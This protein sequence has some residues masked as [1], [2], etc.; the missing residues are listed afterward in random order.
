MHTLLILLS[1]SLASGVC[2]L[3]IAFLRTERSSAARRAVQLVGLFVPV[4]ILGLLGVVMAHFLVKTCF[5]GA[6]PPD[7]AL[8]RVLS[9]VGA[10]GILAALA[11]NTVRALLLPVHMRR[12]TWQA[13]VWLQ[14]RVATLAAQAG[15]RGRP[16]VRV[17]LD[18]RPWALV[19]GL[20]RPCVVISSGLASLLDREELDAVLW[21]ELAHISRR[22]LLYTA[23]AGVLSDLTWFL[24]MTRYLYGLLVAEQ[25]L[26]CDD[27]VR[28]ESHRLALASALTRVRHAQVKPAPSPQGALSFFAAPRRGS[29]CSN[30]EARVRRLLDPPGTPTVTMPFRTVWTVGAAAG[31]FAL[32]QFGAILA[33]MES[34]GCGASQFLMVMP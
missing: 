22:D 20:L 27:H 18:A 34:M 6:P 26:A 3:C 24:P 8:S 25:E 30:F 5:I 33:A 10:V 16:D 9:G 1:L 32:V 13:P 23:L 19:T 11:L 12:H 15:L 21:H 29:G 28:N 2:C 17:S 31:F 7:V 4:C 14:S